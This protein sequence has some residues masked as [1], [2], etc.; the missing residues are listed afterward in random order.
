MYPYAGI[1]KK[2]D[3]GRPWYRGY[4]TAKKILRAGLIS[5]YP[6]LEEPPTTADE[7]LLPKSFEFGVTIS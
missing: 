7:F 4:G 6:L 2:I 1:S 3:S 5:E